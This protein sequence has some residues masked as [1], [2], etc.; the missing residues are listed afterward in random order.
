MAS[1]IERPIKTCLACKKRACEGTCSTCE[2]DVEVHVDAVL[3]ARKTARKFN[4]GS[5]DVE[6]VPIA[7]NPWFG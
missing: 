3:P 7:D 1:T 6:E 4:A 5:H 2:P